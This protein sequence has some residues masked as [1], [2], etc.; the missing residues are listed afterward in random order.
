M[1]RFLLQILVFSAAFAAT[2]APAQTIDGGAYFSPITDNV[3]PLIYGNLFSKSYRDGKSRKSTV[4]RQRSSRPGVY[5]RDTDRASESA[6]DLS[7]AF[8]P[9]ISTRVREDYIASIARSSG[10]KA[11]SGLDDYYRS[12]D[13]R[14]LLAEAMNPYGLRSDDFSDITTAYFAAC[15]RICVRFFSTMHRCRLP[16][17]NGSVLRN[18]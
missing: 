18:P 8:D 11:A 1:N 15:R 17:R 14:A 3:Q 12:H 9:A 4:T 5:P 13:A 6:V 7:I 10:K 2:A 16:P